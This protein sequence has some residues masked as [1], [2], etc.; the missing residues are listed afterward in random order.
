MLVIYMCNL[1][2]NTN[3]QIY[4]M[5]TNSKTQKSNLWSLKGGRDKVGSMG[6]TYTNY[7]I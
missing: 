2:N 5:E 4:K 1:K 6:L 7:Y 3:K